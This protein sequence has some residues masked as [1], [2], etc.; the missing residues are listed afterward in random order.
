MDPQVRAESPGVPPVAENVEVV[1]GPANQEL[2]RQSEAVA[3]LSKRAAPG[4]ERQRTKNPR[5]TEGLQPGL[6]CSSLS[7]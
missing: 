2:S 7:L 5:L 3:I 1:T 4:W 6:F